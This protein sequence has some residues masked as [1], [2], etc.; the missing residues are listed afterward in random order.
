MLG[1]SDSNKDG[2][3]LTSDWELY[4]AERVLIEVFRRHGVRLRLFH[5]RGGTVG[6]GG[7]PSYEA[8][9]AQPPGARAGRDPRH[10]A[11]RGDRR[12]VLQPRRRPAQP[13]DPR[14]RHA[15]GDAARSR[16]PAAAAPNI[17]RSMEELSA[18]AFRA[19]RAL[20]YE[21]PGFDRYFRE[22]TVHRRRSRRST[23]AAV[24]PRA[25]SRRGIEDLRAIPWVFS[26]AQCRLMLP[27]WY[28][29]GA[30]VER[31]GSADARRRRAARCCRRMHDE[32]PFFRTLLSN[33]DMVL[34]KSDIAHRLALRRAGRRRGAA[35]RRSSRA[36]APNGRPRSTRCSPSLRAARRCSTANPLLARSIRNRFPYIDPLNHV[37]IELLRR[38]RAGDSD[39]PAWC[40]ASTSPSTA[41]PPASATAVSD[42]AISACQPSS[43]WRSC[44]LSGGT[45]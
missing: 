41:S 19:Y 9:L 29:F 12:Q 24:R 40:R 22:S 10:R 16:A 15:R 42:Q 13:R 37:Q 45:L 3:Y 21:T 26:W 43:S 6:R 28:G 8:I 38:H 17:S 33:M 2:G 30:A 7:G 32:W 20:V 5:G 34:A 18:H 44:T 25:R 35:R 4:K 11:G 23:S 27:G 14:R 39:R 1:Y 36:C 31:S